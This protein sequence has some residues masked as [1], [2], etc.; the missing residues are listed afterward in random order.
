[1]AEEAKSVITIDV[2]A[3]AFDNFKAVFDQFQASL[4]KLPAQ[5][6]AVKTAQ[7]DTQ[8]AGVASAQAAADKLAEI[9]DKLFKR[10]EA[11][12]AATEKAS[13]KRL[14]DNLAKAQTKEEKEALLAQ[15]KERKQIAADQA[16]A[17]K[18]AKKADAELEKQKEKQRKQDDANAKSEAKKAEKLLNEQRRKDD[19]DAK[20]ATKAADK[21][22]KEIEK[23]RE[24]QRK[25]E[26]ADAKAAASALEK[27]QR[28]IQSKEDSERRAEEKKES[29]ARRK[30]EKDLA[31]AKSKEERELL[32]TQE[33]ARKKT[34]AEEAANKKKA[35]KEARS[36]Q[37]EAK[38]QA[39]EE[40]KQL[41]ERRQRFLDFAVKGLAAF[42]GFEAIAS[43]LQKAYEFAEKT[44]NLRLE[45]RSLGVTPNQ[46][47]NIE[48]NYGTVLS[49][50]KSLLEGIANL[51]TSNAGLN[52][53]RIINPSITTEEAK[54][55]SAADLF[56]K[57]IEGIR[58]QAKK[59]PTTD[60]A[61]A[62]GIDQ[63]LSESDRRAL[64]NARQE[65]IDQIKETVG[66]QKSLN[67]TTDN[68]L[69]I[70]SDLYQTM[71]YFSTSLYNL[72]LEDLAPVAKILETI[73]RGLAEL[74]DVM[75][76]ISTYEKHAIGKAASYIPLVGNY[77]N[78]A[79]GGAE[80][81]NPADQSRSPTTRLD[82]MEAA[83]KAAAAS[84]AT[85][86]AP[87][88]ARVAADA[89]V[90]GLSRAERNHNPGNLTSPNRLFRWLNPDK[91]DPQGFRKFKTDEEGFKAMKD[92]LMIYKNIYK[93]DTLS[94]IIS[95]WAPP[96]SNPTGAYI[97]RVSKET[98]FDANAKLNLND[99]TT[100]SRLMAAMA[101]VE[102]PRSQYSAHQ[103]E[104]M[105][106]NN[107]GGSAV[108][109]ASAMSS[110]MGMR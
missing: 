63:L 43:I 48:N 7:A 36:R 28:E 32:R 97:Q 54:Y 35:E 18:A 62:L 65:E 27:T 3:T 45:S 53:L 108:I 70:W 86:A 93:K 87:Q 52:K 26:D 47:Q 66:L 102:N 68:N 73:L 21:A 64:V 11:R 104:L 5:W 51:Q 76:K 101:R 106:N 56:P 6:A 13:A 58:E 77:I 61:K 20:A 78:E 110:A 4:D 16:A 22:Q 24:K 75:R 10:D 40:K 69:K 103:V 91:V 94:S 49:S 39:D 98:G 84:A 80:A 81:N 41:D 12:Q 90:K 85:A 9:A 72:V 42:E 29:D 74:M 50:P 79:L 105:I 8:N 60:Y 17:E 46:L 109:S 19:A 100:I 59:N 37:Q 15:E 88:A 96:S 33:A 67:S 1:M 31:K 83:Q 92:Q 107:T 44:A 23:D 30:H 95:R 57:I 25:K 55:G 38:K 99:T 71:K 34:L 89:A 2:D 14:E 82:A